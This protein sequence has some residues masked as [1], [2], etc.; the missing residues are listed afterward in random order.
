MPSA[1]HSSESAE[2]YTP[3]EIVAPARLVL[4]GIDLDPFS[5]EL[6]NATVGAVDYYTAEEDGFA[7]PWWGRVF[8]NPPGGKRGNESLQALAWARLV[9]EIERGAV[10]SAIFVCFNLGILQVAQRYGVTPLDFPMCYPR[11]RVA[12]LAKHV[13][14]NGEAFA[15]PGAS[16]P[17][18]SAIVGVNVNPVAFRAAFEAPLGKVVIPV[19][20]GPPIKARPH[21]PPDRR[22]LPLFGAP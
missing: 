4:G 18:P 11:S 8:C 20:D 13:D 22:Q 14:G 12:Y 5:C 19:T 9:S 21:A 3:I 16:P 6:A 10:S 2:H 7:C 15:R 1:M 17:H